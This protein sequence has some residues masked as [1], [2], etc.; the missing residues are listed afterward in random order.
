MPAWAWLDM[1]V[2]SLLVLF[3]TG[4]PIWLVLNRPDERPVA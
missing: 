3:T 4:I 1:A 2:A